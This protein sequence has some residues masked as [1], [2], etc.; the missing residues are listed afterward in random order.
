[1]PYEIILAPEAAGDLQ[2]LKANIRAAVKD[3]IKDY[4]RHEPK[5]TSKARIKRLRGVSRP[6]H[7]LRA[8]DIRIFYDVTPNT[9]AILAIISKTEA[10]TWLERAGEEDETDRAVGSQG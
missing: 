1:M 6:Q 5:K 8:D 9:V 4:L 2:H 7:R 3:A 10:E